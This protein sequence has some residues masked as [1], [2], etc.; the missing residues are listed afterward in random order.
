MDAR[1]YFESK[2]WESTLYKYVGDA[3][4]ITHRRK[5]I[6]LNTYINEEERLIN[7]YQGFQ[8]RMIEKQTKPIIN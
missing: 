7:Y 5:F 8:E 2:C 4:K 3:A 1:R 6:F